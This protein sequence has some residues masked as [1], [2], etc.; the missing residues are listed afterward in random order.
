[1]IKPITISDDFQTEK[2]RL[3]VIRNKINE[4]VKQLNEKK[5]P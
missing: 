4:I 5:A 2:E 1:M 3:E